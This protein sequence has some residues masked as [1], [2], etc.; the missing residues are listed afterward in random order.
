MVKT[1][2]VHFSLFVLDVLRWVAELLDKTAINTNIDVK[3]NGII[4]KRLGAFSWVLL[5]ATN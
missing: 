3:I 5:K 1:G 4:N 2:T